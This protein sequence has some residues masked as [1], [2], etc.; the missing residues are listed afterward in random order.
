MILDGSLGEGGGQILRTALALSMVTGRAFRLEKIRA[1]RPKPGL[2]RQHLTAVKA[3][4]CVCNA[5]VVGADLGSVCLEFRPAEVVPGEYAFAVGTAGSATLVLQTLLPPLLTASAPSSLTLEGGTHNPAAPP[6][7][8]LARCF[9]P[10]LH[11]MGPR[12]DLE[13][14]RPGFYPAGGGKF[15]VSIRPS[16]TLNPVEILDRGS[17]L[18]RVARALHANI[19]VRVAQR[20]LEV[21]QSRLGWQE[22]EGVVEGVTQSQGPGNAVMLEIQAEQITEV[23]AAFGERH[24]SAESVAEEACGCAAQWLEANVPVGEYLA[25]QLMIPMAL[26]GAGSFRTVVPSLHSKTN[27]QIIER[28]LPV[29]FVFEPESPLAWRVCVRSL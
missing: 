10:V 15:H 28:F 16:P 23:F 26:A 2:S 3:A 18:R 7:D 1:G 24:R 6:F 19:P 20:E 27:A 5:D 22:N 8:F 14:I 9:V 25:D 21:V 17:I 4:A 13:L 29:R 11:R 12:I